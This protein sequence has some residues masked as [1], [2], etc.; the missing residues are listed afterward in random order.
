MSDLTEKSGYFEFYDIITQDFIPPVEGLESFKITN[1]TTWTKA[2]CYWLENKFG[3]TIQQGDGSTMGIINPQSFYYNF[4]ASLREYFGY[5]NDWRQQLGSIKGVYV[6]PVLE[7]SWAGFDDNRC[8]SFF[9]NMDL[10]EVVTEMPAGKTVYDYAFQEENNRFDVIIKKS[11][12]NLGIRIKYPLTTTGTTDMS[13]N[14]PRFSHNYNVTVSVPGSTIVDLRENISQPLINNTKKRYNSG[15]PHYLY[16]DTSCT[17]G[18]I[19]F[20][21][22][23]TNGHNYIDSFIQQWCNND[24]YTR[25]NNSTMTTER[26]QF[27]S[28]PAV[29]NIMT[30][31]FKFEIKCNGYNR[32]YYKTSFDNNVLN[33]AITNS[34]GKKVF[35]FVLFDNSDNTNTILLSNE[36]KRPHY[37]AHS[38]NDMSKWIRSN[39]IDNY[40]LDNT[41]YGIYGNAIVS[42]HIENDKFLAELLPVKYHYDVRDTDHS[43]IDETGK[44]RL[45]LFCPF[46]EQ[47]LFTKNLFLVTRCGTNELIGRDG[48]TIIGNLNN[49]RTKFL[50]YSFNGVNLQEDTDDNNTLFAIPIEQ[51]SE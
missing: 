8:P 25:V 31:N 18:Y 39:G 17:L 50:V 28:Y 51:L 46:R 29:N 27:V 21:D 47:Q 35:E 9:Q 5:D 41:I 37:F 26:N 11:N 19:T 43:L 42:N 36:I 4:A 10:W 45:E 13:G 44:W 7:N 1:W 34:S 48:T 32:I 38:R 23:V 16:D 20:L 30:D 2:L 14:N 6:N 3:F 49:Q 40:D 12:N 24:G 33:I 15:S 22:N